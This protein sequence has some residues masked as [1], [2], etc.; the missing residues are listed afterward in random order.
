MMTQAKQTKEKAVVED[1]LI[2]TTFR[3]PRSLH[4]RVVVRCAE[5]DVKLTDIVAD[6]LRQ[7]VGDKKAA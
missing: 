2:Q 4:R 5:L 1:R 3:I 6:G 7:F